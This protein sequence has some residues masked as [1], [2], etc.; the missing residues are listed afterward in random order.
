MLGIIGKLIRFLFSILLIPVCIAVTM[1]FYNCL[2]GIK[3]LPQSSLYFLSGVLA[4]CLMHLLL[5]KPDF[6]Y[7]FGH[8][9]MHAIT[10]FLSGG[11]ASS[12]K[13]SS[14]EGSVKT[15][16]PN[17]FVILAPYIIPSYTVLIAVLYFILIL[18]TQVQNF[19]KI[20]IFLIGF[21]LMLH[22][23]YTAESI[24]QKQ[25]DLIKTGYLFSLSFI[26]IINVSLVF[27]ILT[28]L[29]REVSFLSFLSS[30]YE[31]SSEIYFGLFKQ[32]FL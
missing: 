23:S 22:L 4:Y 32:L 1:S 19:L 13:V 15:T 10:T 28:L 26:Y 6:L 12:M 17:F 21:T 25:S 31:I 30:S 7:V 9:S 16:K 29:V 8:E 3:S 20:F 11:K 18:F 27:F 2:S 14:K 24:R 5:F